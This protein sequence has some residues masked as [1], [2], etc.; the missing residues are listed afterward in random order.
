MVDMF[1]TWAETGFTKREAD[2]TLAEKES[3][4]RDVGSGLVEMSVTYRRDLCHKGGDKFYTGGCEFYI[5]GGE[6]YK[7][8]GQFY[9]GGD[10]FYIGAYKG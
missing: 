7:G 10:E 3:L 6:F 1:S 8:G 9:I 2:V 4:G 5:G